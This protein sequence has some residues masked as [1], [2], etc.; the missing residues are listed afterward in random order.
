MAKLTDRATIPLKQSDFRVLHGERRL[1]DVRLAE[2]LGFDRLRKLR[3]LIARWESFLESQSGKPP[4][5]G[6]VSQARGPEGEA[7]FLTI[8]ELIFI[9]GKSGARNADVVQYEAAQIA[10]LWIEGKTAP[11]DA[12]PTLRALAAP[13]RPQLKAVPNDAPGLFD[14]IQSPVVVPLRPPPAVDDDDANSL[15]WPRGRSEPPLHPESSWRA[16]GVPPRNPPPLDRLTIGAFHIWKRADSHGHI[17][18]IRVSHDGALNTE[19]DRQLSAPH[20]MGAPTN[21]FV[22][23]NDADTPFDV[24]AQAY[25][26]IGR[27]N[28]SSVGIA[29]LKHQW[30]S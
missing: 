22:Y 24:I 10:A 12:A 21:V 25:N 3:D 11:S 2:R 5:R 28:G 20:P 30:M 23:V 27:G 4:H 15:I 17:F 18:T 26:S 8:P 1:S 7:Y 29:T 13:D 19:H 16:P 6:A 14:P 9:A